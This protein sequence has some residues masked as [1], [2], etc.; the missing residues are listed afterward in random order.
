VQKLRE[1]LLMIQQGVDPSELMKKHG[2][3]GKQIIEVEKVIQIEDKEKMRE[4]EEKLQKEKEE[5]KIRAEEEKR[6][7][8][9]EKNL[10]EEE[11]QQLLD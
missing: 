5:I 9:Q 11:K 10:K 8:E 3:M 2:V 1:Q 7:I 6:R 4:F